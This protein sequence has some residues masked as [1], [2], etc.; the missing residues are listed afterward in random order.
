MYNLGM[1]KELYMMA[2]GV[3]GLVSFLGGSL[4]N[5]WGSSSIVEMLEVG[6]MVHRW[7]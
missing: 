1:V 5:D 4:M 6:H 3:V 7:V 2:V